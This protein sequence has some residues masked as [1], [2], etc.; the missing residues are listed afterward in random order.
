MSIGGAA[1]TL[2]F[3]THEI[4]RGK[5]DEVVQEHGK[6]D[7][8]GHLEQAVIEAFRCR[9]LEK[10]RNIVRRRG[11]DQSESIRLSL[12]AWKCAYYVL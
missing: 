6:K 7:R 5:R 9:C 8:S 2:E 11:R 12:R 10:E 3:N 4:M 1:K